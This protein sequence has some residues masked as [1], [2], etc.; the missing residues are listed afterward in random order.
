[1]IVDA[2][3]LGHDPGR[4]RVIGLDRE[5]GVDVVVSFASADHMVRSLGVIVRLTVRGNA[6]VP[7]GLGFISAQ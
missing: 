3:R 1:L 6:S 2:N 5:G 4:R 7:F